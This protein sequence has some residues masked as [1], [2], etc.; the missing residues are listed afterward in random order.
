MYATHHTSDPRIG[1]GA[2][3]GTGAAPPAPRHRRDGIMPT[4]AAA[5]SARGTTLTCAAAKA[6][7]RP[8]HHPLVQDFLDTL[9]TERRERH[10]GH[11]PEAV[12]LSRYL[13]GAESARSKRAAR[14]P[15]TAGDARRALKHAKITT[16]RIREEGDPQHGTYA[17]P[18]RSCA[19]LLAHFGVLAVEPAPTVRAETATSR[20]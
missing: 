20:R 10:T 15:F 7:H 3:N 8:G 17:P 1:W 4:T 5:L 9:T 16:R 6:G 14:K 18:C 19:A 13:T 2:T 12:L 11:C